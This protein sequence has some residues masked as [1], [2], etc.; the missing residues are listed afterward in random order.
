MELT[1]GPHGGDAHRLAAAL[2]VDPAEILDLSASLNPVAVDPR[3]IVARHLDALGRYPDPGRAT[4][5]LAEAMAVDQDRLVLTNGGAEAIALVA[6]QQ[7]SAWAETFDFSL[8]RRHIRKLDPAGPRWGSDPH[9]PSGVLAQPGDVA[10]V[11][12]EAFYLLATG[13]WTRGDAAST[14]VGSLTKAFSVPGLR[15]GYVLAPNAA[16][17]QQLRTAQPQWALNGLAAAALPDLLAT[18]EPDRWVREIAELRDQLA[19]LLA[20]HGHTEISG[21]ANWLWVT[22]AKGLRQRLLPSGVLLRSGESFGFPDAV[23]IAVP[24]PEGL[25]LLQRALQETTP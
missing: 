15:I 14:V 24:N 10:D 5:A 1:P 21:D 3:P 17:A 8:Y 20:G 6:A 12:D 22:D 7:E 16:V 4:A 2:H 13:R 18:A 11:R 25:T 23:R 9:N 19:T